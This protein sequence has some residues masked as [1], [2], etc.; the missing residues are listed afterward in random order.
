MIAKI[1]RPYPEIP[2]LAASN[3]KKNFFDI[4]NLVLLLSQ[5]RSFVRNPFNIDTK[6]FLL[7]LIVT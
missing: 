6:T 4:I 7:F 3:W 1:V 2:D 5:D